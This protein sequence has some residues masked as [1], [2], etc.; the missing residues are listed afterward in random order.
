MKT[1][2]DQRDGFKKIWIKENLDVLSETIRADRDVYFA[3][4]EIFMPIVMGNQRWKEGLRV[5]LKNK[6][7]FPMNYK[8]IYEEAFVILEIENKWRRYEAEAKYRV[9]KN[10]SDHKKAFRDDYAAENSFPLAKWTQVEVR[11]KKKKFRNIEWDAKGLRRYLK[12]IKSWTEDMT[13]EE[14]VEV[15]KALVQYLLR[16]RGN[17]ATDSERVDRDEEERWDTYSAISRFQVHYDYGEVPELP[18]DLLHNERRTDEVSQ[19]RDL[20]IGQTG[21]V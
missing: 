5:A 6:A 19:Q 8:T 18:G 12:M 7:H 14:R 20:N 21:A 4:V 11:G 1:E 10:M 9:E 15:D 13:R 3:F 17:N 2:D 16:R